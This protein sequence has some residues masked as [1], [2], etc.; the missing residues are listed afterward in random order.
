MKQK[1]AIVWR[2]WRNVR[3]Q[4][5]LEAFQVKRPI[6]ASL[7]RLRQKTIEFIFGRDDLDEIG[8]IKIRIGNI[9]FGIVKTCHLLYS[10]HKKI[11][12]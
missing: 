6:V 11:V 3:R 12:Q 4:H 1:N 5:P 7:P 10:P 9:L 8:V 2:R